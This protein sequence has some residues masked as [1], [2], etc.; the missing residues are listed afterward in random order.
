[1]SIDQHLNQKAARKGRLFFRPGAPFL[2]PN[3]FSYV[4]DFFAESVEDVIL[5]RILIDS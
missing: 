3:S 1:M 5:L 2:I 4:G